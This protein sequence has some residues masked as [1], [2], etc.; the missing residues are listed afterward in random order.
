MIGIFSEVLDT[1]AR[2]FTKG[3]KLRSFF[4]VTTIIVATTAYYL[5]RELNLLDISHLG[6]P[7]TSK[8]YKF[9]SGSPGGFYTYVGTALELAAMDG[10]TLKIKNVPTAGSLENAI[11]VMTSHR[12]FGLSQEESL[13]RDEFMKEKVRFITPL[14]MS[15][16]HVIYNKQAFAKYVL[17]EQKDILPQISRISNLSVLNFFANSK[18]NLGPVGSSASLLGDPLL[19]EM[20]GQ[21]ND[22][23]IYKGQHMNYSSAIAYQL[24]RN[25]DIDVMFTA[26][27]APIHIIDSLLSTEKFGLMGIGA[28]MVHVLY[29]KYG[30]NVRSADFVDTYENLPPTSTIG[31][32]A[33]L[34][35]SEDASNSDILHVLQ[36]LNSAKRSIKILSGQE[37]LRNFQLDEFDFLESFYAEH[38]KN[39]WQK[40]GDLFVLIVSIIISTAVALTILL[41]FISSHKQN[42]HF[43]KISKVAINAIPDN[44]ILGCMVKEDRDNIESGQIKKHKRESRFPIPL[45]TK[46]MKKVIVKIVEGISR[47]YS[48]RRNINEDYLNGEITDSHHLYLL[49]HESRINLK[50]RNILAQKL[51][52]Y[53]RKNKPIPIEDLQAYYTA[54][55]LVK[56]DYFALRDTHYQL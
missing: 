36:I 2:L 22:S 10:N 39:F 44:I 49:D 21:L 5:V 25:G 51:R 19:A 26:V 30:V 7:F 56:E 14:Y 54:G 33:F 31:S 40:L 42:M 17:P 18:I 37:N 13:Q 35:A 52:A 11:K 50:L 29:E 55:Y 6:L 38:N 47:L 3:T 32:Y 45:Q 27:G 34:I 12:A 4:F 43:R 15:R 46:N 48:I 41:W 53:F 23:D 8:T 24:L 16:L 1:L 20:K 28:T 9:Y